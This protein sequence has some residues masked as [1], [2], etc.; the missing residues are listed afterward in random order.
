MSSAGT[1]CLLVAE[2][3]DACCVH[4]MR[5]MYEFRISTV[6]ELPWPR[7]WLSWDRYVW[8]MQVIVQIGQVKLINIAK[9]HALSAFVL[10]SQT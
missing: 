1:L 8:H 10:L 5:L 3:G 2:N 4:V 6:S 7:L 9:P